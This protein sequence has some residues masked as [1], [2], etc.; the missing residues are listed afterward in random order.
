MKSIILFYIRV[1]K[2]GIP[3]IASLVVM[4]ITNYFYIT[5]HIRDITCITNMHVKIVDTYILVL[6]KLKI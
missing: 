1:F 4:C 2:N 5:S 6:K 3:G